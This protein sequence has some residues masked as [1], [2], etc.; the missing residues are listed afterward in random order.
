MYHEPR[1]IRNHPIARRILVFVK[2]LLIVLTHKG[3]NIHLQLWKIVAFCRFYV[4]VDD[5]GHVENHVVVGRIVVVSVQIP[6][7]G[8]FMDFHVT[9]PKRS[10]DFHLGIE[11]VGSRMM[12]VQSGVYDFHG[13]SVSG[14][15]FFER[16]DPKT[17][18]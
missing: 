11:E 18:G 8:A 2:K 12:V 16:K 14:Y 17:F 9:H 13:L 7:A 5:S 10:V 1:Q 3:R 15:H 4:T 6:V